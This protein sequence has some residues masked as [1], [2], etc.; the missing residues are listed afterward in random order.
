MEDM[1]LKELWQSYHEKVEAN[2]QINR[3]NA[4]DISKLKAQTYLLSMRP[5]KIFTIIIGLLWV[6]GVY[7]FLLHAFQMRN[8]FFLVSA[9][10]QVVLT[11][12][13]IG[14]YIYQLVLINQIDLSLPIVKVQER[15]AQLKSSTL[16]IARF[17]F[18]QLPVWSTFYLH[19]DL[20][21]NGVWGLWILQIAIT[22][23][24]TGLALWLFFN[25]RNENRHKRWF[26]WIFQGS[27]WEPVIKAMEMLEEIEEYRDQ[28]A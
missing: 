25:I 16:W 15:L 18:L 13:A 6:I 14:V 8:Y 22:I 20:F 27:D 3:K 19:R 26:R 23:S 1:D 24:L 4:E 5:W 17:L 9:S 11:Q 7:M 21:R 28:A 10:I 2:L 12:L